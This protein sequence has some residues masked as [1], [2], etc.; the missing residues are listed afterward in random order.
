M[1]SLSKKFFIKSYLLLNKEL[2]D[3]KSDMRKECKGKVKTAPRVGVNA[4]YLS[5][6]GISSFP[7][8]SNVSL[9]VTVFPSGHNRG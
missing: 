5:T 7:E 4:V 2:F 1:S 3:T 8:K 6:F 9:E